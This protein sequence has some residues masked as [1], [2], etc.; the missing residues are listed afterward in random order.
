MFTYSKYRNDILPDLIVQ[1]YVF[2]TLFNERLINFQTFSHGCL[3][4]HAAFICVKFDKF[5]SEECKLSFFVEYMSMF[6]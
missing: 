5:L 4:R 2:T 6:H 1:F 3:V